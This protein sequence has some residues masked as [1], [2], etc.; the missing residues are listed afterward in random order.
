MRAF[1]QLVTYLIILLNPIFLHAQDVKQNS[2]F[3]V[4]KKTK[5]TNE[6]IINPGAQVRALGVIDVPVELIASGK[7]FTFIYQDQVLNAD[8]TNFEIFQPSKELGF[9]PLRSAE[10]A[11]G[12]G[13]CSRF[14]D[15][16][17]G[18]PLNFQ[19]DQILPYLRIFSEGEVVSNF[20]VAFNEAI[21]SQLC[22]NGLEF[23]RSYAFNL[24]QGLSYKTCPACPS[25]VLSESI[26]I[27]GQTQPRQPKI[28]L[29]PSKTILPL[30]SKNN[31]LT[32]F[33]S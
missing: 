18:T 6:L 5:T 21:S 16:S 11:S 23:S 2:T 33:G 9:S 13:L 12:A 31:F 22:V 19:P 28:E 1:L 3:N 17:S 32:G 29:D 25:T 4:I 15:Q 10:S 14:Y 26:Q 30:A 24:L 8:F 27:Y 20:S 7:L